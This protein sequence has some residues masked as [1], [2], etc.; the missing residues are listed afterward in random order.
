MNEGKANVGANS[1]LVWSRRS[2]RRPL[3]FIVARLVPRSDAN[4]S[5]DCEL[6]ALP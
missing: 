6:S 2:D 5:M 1:T 3:I 4:A